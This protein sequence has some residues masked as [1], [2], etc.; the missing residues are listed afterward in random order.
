[1]ERP[2]PSSNKENTPTQSKSPPSSNATTQRKK[3]NPPSNT[4]PTAIVAQ[5]NLPDTPIIIVGTHADKLSKQELKKRIA[6]VQQMYPFS[7]HP[8]LQ[9]HFIVGLASGIDCCN[10]KSQVIKVN[11]L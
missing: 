1:L 8:Q 7:K 3:S 2:T 10:I 6:E 11:K 9:G 4:A 5:N